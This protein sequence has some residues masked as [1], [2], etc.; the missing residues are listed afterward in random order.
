QAYGYAG[1]VEWNATSV[2]AYPAPS[3]PIGGRIVITVFASP[4]ASTEYA[5]A[6]NNLVK[7]PSYMHNPDA[8]Y[9]YNIIKEPLPQT[10][11]YPSTLSTDGF[12]ENYDNA[13]NIAPAT[14]FYSKYN[15]ALSKHKLNNVPRIVVGTDSMFDLRYLP[16]MS[17][18]TFVPNH[19]ESGFSFDGFWKTTVHPGYEWDYIYPI[20]WQDADVYWTANR[21]D[22]S[23]WN[24]NTG[25]YGQKITGGFAAI[26]TGATAA[27][28]SRAGGRYTLVVDVPFASNYSFGTITVRYAV[29]LD[30]TNLGQP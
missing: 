16:T 9:G 28:S 6:Q 13:T 27:G 29:A 20:P 3:E 17:L 25:Y 8:M 2:R 23:Q 10:W 5:G 18:R 7:Y 26:N 15:T 14:N 30:I 12:E 22:P 24:H 11:I 19:T 21:N 4:E 1:Y